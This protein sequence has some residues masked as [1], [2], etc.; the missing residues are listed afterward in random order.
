MYL[1]TYIHIPIYYVLILC[2]CSV[3]VDV[4]VEESPGSPPAQ[5]KNALSSRME[6]LEKQISIE[7]KVKSGAENMIKMYYAG[8]SKDKKLLQEA[9]QALQD[10]KTKLEVLR[11]RRMKLAS[12]LENGESSNGKQSTA[13]QSPEGRI[14]HLRYRIHVEQEVIKGATRMKQV[15]QDKKAQQ[16][17]SSS[18]TSFCCS[19]GY[20]V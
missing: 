5:R 1:R 17:V 13:V 3:D 14:D 8:K 16:I 18:N 4:S 11:M 15:A 2:V 9:Q 19:P 20:N 10:S 7:Q 12:Q 6:T